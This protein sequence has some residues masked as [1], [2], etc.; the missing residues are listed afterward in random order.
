MQRTFNPLN[1]ERYPGGPPTFALSFGSASQFIAGS[2]NSRTSPFEGDRGGASPSPAAS[3]L[4][5]A[6]TS[7][8]KEQTPHRAKRVTACKCF[9]ERHLEQNDC[10]GAKPQLAGD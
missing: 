10:A 1:R 6:P 8:N 3:F 5:P 2:F 4:G 9:Y 7:I